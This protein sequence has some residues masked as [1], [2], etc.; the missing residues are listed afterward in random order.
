MTRTRAK[1]DPVRPSAP[2]PV[3]AWLDVLVAMLAIPR[4]DRHRVRDELEDHLRSRIDDLLIHG[5]TGA[6]ALQK[7][8]AEL[9]ETADL[10]RQLSHAHRTPRTR[11][12]AMHALLIA[13]TG[14]VVALSVNTMRPVP[15]AGT[16]PATASE[17]EAV[18]PIPA[19]K[20]T[21]RERTIGQ[22][23]EEYASLADRSVL[24][25]WP[26]LAQIGLLPD[27]ELGMDV[28]PLPAEAVFAMIAE[29]DFPNR[30][31][32]GSIDTLVGPNLIEIGTRSQFDLRTMQR[33]SYDASMLMGYGAASPASRARRQNPGMGQRGES[34]SVSEGAR[35]VAML[36]ETHI[37]PSDWTNNGGELAQHSVMGT[38]IIVTAP[39]RMHREI[40]V[41]IEE[42]AR[43]QLQAEEAG[44]EAARRQIEALASNFDELEAEYGRLVAEWESL[45]LSGASEQSSESGP[46]PKLDVAAF[47]RRDLTERMQMIRIRQSSITSARDQLIREWGFQSDPARKAV[48][49]AAPHGAAGPVSFAQFFPLNSQKSILIPIPQDAGLKLSQILASQGFTGDEP[50]THYVYIQRSGKPN[51]EFMRTTVRQ[52]FGRADADHSVGPGDRVEISTHLRAAA[53][54]QRTP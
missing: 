3:D 4:A 29:R 34:F 12:Y 1:P 5:L 21:V 49:G 7:A 19:L 35:G 50:V 51:S 10:A 47:K 25:H 54:S 39:E 30:T 2:D 17:T 28:D 23:L 52:V 14:T 26:M 24:V 11:R 13:L 42:L 9:G 46:N 44:R 31:L 41:F 33:K 8:V 43:T 20:L 53:E 48:S 16:A 27:T 32:D 37:S 40:A 6:Q 45:T 36:L 22:L 15:V 18:S 38:T